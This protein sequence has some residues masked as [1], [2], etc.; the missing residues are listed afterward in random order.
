M[1]QIR[2]KKSIENRNS[3]ILNRTIDLPYA[4]Q[5]HVLHEEQFNRLKYFH[6]LTMA[7]AIVKSEFLKLVKLSRER[8]DLK[9]GPQ[10][11]R[12]RE[13]RCICITQ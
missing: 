1:I 2:R 12:R 5:Q 10:Q 9:N 6:N 8:G 4:Q 3:P 11:V 7:V 13:A